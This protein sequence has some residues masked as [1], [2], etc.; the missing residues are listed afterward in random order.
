ME[1]LTESAAQ[2]FL[3]WHSSLFSLI[4]RFS[5]V[6]RLQSTST[7]INSLVTA[8]KL[9]MMN[10]GFQIEMLRRITF[11]PIFGLVPLV[12]SFSKNSVMRRV[13]AAH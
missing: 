6:R 3:A 12:V 1:P 4:G 9:E 5:Q 13:L 11:H 2:A 10:E 8:G 7:D